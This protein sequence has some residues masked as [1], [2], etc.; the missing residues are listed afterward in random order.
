MLN[1]K[2][3]VITKTE[4]YQH[5]LLAGFTIHV[6]IIHLAVSQQAVDSRLTHKLLGLYH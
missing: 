2:R 4:Q 6:N 1:K 3:N 5:S